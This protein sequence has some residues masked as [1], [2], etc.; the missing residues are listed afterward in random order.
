MHSLVL[1]QCARYHLRRASQH[2]SPQKGAMPVPRWTPF[3]GVKSVKSRDDVRSPVPVAVLLAAP[4]LEVAERFKANRYQGHLY[5]EHNGHDSH[6][7]DEGNSEHKQPR[8]AY[9]A[10]PHAAARGPQKG[11]LGTSTLEF[12]RR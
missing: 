7:Q 2:E 6:E 3:P 9:A 4:F 12:S 10:T 11:Q 1:G 8:L 5:R